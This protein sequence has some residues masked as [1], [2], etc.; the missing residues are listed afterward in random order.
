M[1]RVMQ[2]PFDHPQ[3]WDGR[4]RGIFLRHLHVG[5]AVATLGALFAF[6]LRETTGSMGF[7]LVVAVVLLAVIVVLAIP[8]VPARVDRRRNTVAWIVLALA[9]LLLLRVLLFAWS[10]PTMRVPLPQQ[11]PGSD[12]TVTYLFVAQLIA[13]LALL[14][15]SRWTAAAVSFV[16]L[17]LG[18][19]F[20]AG[21][22]IGVGLLLGDVGT[23]ELR[24]PL[25]VSWAA[26][27]AAMLAMFVAFLLLVFAVVLTAR[28]FGGR[29]PLP[30]LERARRAARR[31]DKVPA[32]TAVVM[33][34]LVP[35]F[36]GATIVVVAIDQG[37]ADELARDTSGPAWR[38]LTVLGG[39][40]IALFALGL[41][42]LARASFRNRALRRQVGIAWD[43]A[44]FW[45]RH[46]HPLAPPC[47]AERAVPE[48]SQRVAYLTSGDPHDD[49]PNF[50]TN[51]V[52]VSAHSQGSVIAAAALLRQGQAVDRIVLVTYG[53][54]LDRLY[55]RYFPAYFGPETT[56]VLAHR[57]DGRWVNLF[58]TTDPIGGPVEAAALDWD[59]P[60]RVHNGD[61]EGHSHYLQETMYSDAIAQSEFWLSGRLYA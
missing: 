34:V 40:I 9:W 10:E 51:P 45:P 16:A 11:L 47:Y 32:Y 21:I 24:L 54:P 30:P 57:L 42:L 37:W 41:L 61:V 39:R 53:S 43:I 49:D 19:A 1:P 17:S 15:V 20:G 33:A 12:R 23:R 52:V 13:I 2:T 7:E 60:V 25:G 38:G 58:R 4:A 46:A 8:E 50:T 36:V 56:R 22:V 55:T 18:A 3:L 31:T 14:V 29:P 27:V 5:G 35:L 6:A 28:R 59:V 44:T 48:L 26:R